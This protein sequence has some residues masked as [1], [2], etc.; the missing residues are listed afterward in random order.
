MTK[1]SSKLKRSLKAQNVLRKK[2]SGLVLMIHPES[3]IP[4]R[5]K[6]GKREIQ[7][8]IGGKLQKNEHLEAAMNAADP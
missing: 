7:T 8:M 2:R 5:N 3:E 1:R 4:K 6:D